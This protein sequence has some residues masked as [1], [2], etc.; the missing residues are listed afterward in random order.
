MK[1]LQQAMQL[2]IEYVWQNIAVSVLDQK[3]QVS[4]IMLAQRGLTLDAWVAV[5]QWCLEQALQTVLFKA[6]IS[7]DFMIVNKGT[8]LQS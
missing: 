6:K 8:W 2:I 1:N 5:R 4:K 7:F 3:Q